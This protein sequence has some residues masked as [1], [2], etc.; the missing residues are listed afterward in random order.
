ALRYPLFAQI[1]ASLHPLDLLCVF[2]TTKILRAVVL[3]RSATSAWKRSFSAVEAAP[4]IP[5]DI[6][7]PH[8]ASLMFENFCQYC[9]KYAP[10]VYWECRARVCKHCLYIQ[11]VRYVTDRSIALTCFSA[12]TWCRKRQSSI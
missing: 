5:D 11:C 10:T 7:I 8:L 12:A 3:S 1:F 9:L 4:S 2:R 6:S